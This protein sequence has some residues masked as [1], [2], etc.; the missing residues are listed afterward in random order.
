MD[1]NAAMEQQERRAIFLSLGKTSIDSIRASRNEQCF[2]LVLYD[3]EDGSDELWQDFRDEE[4]AV[5]SMMSKKPLEKT[6][7]YL[8]PVVANGV[9]IF[10]NLNKLSQRKDEIG[11]ICHDLLAPGGVKLRNSAME[12]RRKIAF[13]KKVVKEMCKYVKAI[14]DEENEELIKKAESLAIKNEDLAIKNENLT[15]KAENLANEY[16]IVKNQNAGLIKILITEGFSDKEIA[17]RA[18]L[19]IEEVEAVRSTL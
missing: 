9:M 4:M 18:N 5:Y 8:F 7:I 2:L 16:N 19:S 10:L 17:S 3:T 1:R 15:I 12:K 11:E 14:C 13:T 6:N